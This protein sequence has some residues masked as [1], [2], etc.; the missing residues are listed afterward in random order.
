MT[1]LK[2]AKRFAA[3][4]DLTVKIDQSG[5]G[6]VT[7]ITQTKKKLDQYPLSYTEFVA[8]I[9]KTLP[10]MKLKDLFAV[11]KEINL[12]NDPTYADYSF[13]TKAQEV[14]YESP[15]ASK[16][17]NEHLQPGC[18]TDRGRAAKRENGG[19]MNGCQALRVNLEHF[20]T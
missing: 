16:G 7:V 12:K 20:S 17:D 1:E 2:S 18:G 13:R 15:Q 14:A 4:A 9:K 19:C 5:A 10:S 3:P 8:Q 6:T 11:M